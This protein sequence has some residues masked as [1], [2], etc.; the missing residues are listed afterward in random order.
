MKHEALFLQMTMV[1]QTG[2]EFLKFSEFK[3][4]LLVPILGQMIPAHTF[5]SYLFEFYFYVT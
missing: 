5:P 4:S 2:N 3:V 1:A